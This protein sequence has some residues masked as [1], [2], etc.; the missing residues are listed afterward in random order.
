MISLFSYLITILAGMFWFLRIVVT[1]CASMGME[2][3]IAPLNLNAEI[4]LLFVTLFALVLVIKR[5]MLGAYVYLVS[6]GGYFGMDVYNIILRIQ[7]GGSINDYTSLLVS[8]L[9]IVLAVLAFFDV[10]F[11]KNRK[12]KFTDKKTDFF[13]A[14]DQYDRKYDERAD[15]NQYK[16]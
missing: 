14:T 2:M 5:N 7:E 16:F 11:N 10:L 6:Y 4:V 1:F 15:R 9:G 3:G 8:F 13:Y 12:G